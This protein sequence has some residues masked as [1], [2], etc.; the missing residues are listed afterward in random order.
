MLYFNIIVYR[1]PGLS[2]VYRWS[3]IH[4]LKM[5]L[6]GADIDQSL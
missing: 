2:I 5:L 6:H 3:K 1:T 4:G